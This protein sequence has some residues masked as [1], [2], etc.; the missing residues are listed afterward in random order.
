MNWTEI[1]KQISPLEN[2]ELTKLIGELYKLNSE[3]KRFLAMRFSSP[4]AQLV[5]YKKLISKAVNPPFSENAKINFSKG[6]QVI[7]SFKKASG[8]LEMLAA[9]MLYYVEEAN[10][11]T[12]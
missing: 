9:L 1:K 5:D 3:N 12:L 7:S 6:R 11:Q 4:E 2:K 8:D 10:E